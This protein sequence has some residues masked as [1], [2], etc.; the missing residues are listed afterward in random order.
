[1][2]WY[3]D[4]K[5]WIEYGGIVKLGIDVSL[6]KIDIQDINVTITLPQAKVLSCKVD[7]NGSQMEVS[8]PEIGVE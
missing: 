3:K 4:K 5:F 8:E 1:M 2:F 6:V 7:E